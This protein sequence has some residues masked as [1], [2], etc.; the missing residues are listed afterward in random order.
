MIRRALMKEGTEN[1][2]DWKNLPFYSRVT[3]AGLLV[4]A[5]IYTGL[6]ILFMVSGGV[7]GN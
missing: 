4:F 2:R 6:T 1:K 5:L 7:E 3:I